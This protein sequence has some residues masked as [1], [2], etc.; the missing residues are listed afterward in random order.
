MAEN[1]KTVVN[2]RVVIQFFA[3]QGKSIQDIKNL[4]GLSTKVIKRWIERDSTENRKG[5]GRKKI[6]DKDDVKVLVKRATDSATTRSQL[7]RKL[8]KRGVVASVSTIGRALRDAG[9]RPFKRPKNSF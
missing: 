4:T 8:E 5:Q 7:K 6:L 9:L 2:N 3:K 1:P